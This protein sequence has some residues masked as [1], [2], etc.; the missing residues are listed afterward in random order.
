[1]KVAVIGSRD[2]TVTDMDRY[3]SDC[4]EIVTGGAVG[5]DLCA[6]EYAKKY[7]LRLTV[8]Y[9]NYRRYG[10]AAPVVRNRQIV[11]YAD[12]VIAFWNGFSGGTAS[13][14]QYAQKTGTPCDV[15]LCEARDI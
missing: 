2:I 3:V 13:V 12:K 7:G 10:R 4:E 15:V 1:M 6:Q 11:D 14:I 8:F 5:V 9:P